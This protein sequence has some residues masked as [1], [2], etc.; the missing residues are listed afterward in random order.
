MVD[1][2]E[3]A[4][5]LGRIGLAKPGW[6]DLEVAIVVDVQT[7]AG[8]TEPSATISKSVGPGPPASTGNITGTDRR[9]PKSDRGL[10]FIRGYGQSN[11]PEPRGRGTCGMF[12]IVDSQVVYPTPPDISRR[13]TTVAATGQPG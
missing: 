6:K 12:E 1:P 8:H 7:T 3:P 2:A 10:I 5:E 9:S 4:A 11:V 13:P